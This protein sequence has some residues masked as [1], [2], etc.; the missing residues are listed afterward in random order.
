MTAWDT[1]D[2]YAAAVPKSLPSPS[3]S[4]HSGRIKL[5]HSSSSSKPVSP[6]LIERQ[7]L[8]A[9]NDTAKNDRYFAITLILRSTNES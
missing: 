6:P 9:D 3:D 5:G 2:E 4:S 8:S 1:E 7:E